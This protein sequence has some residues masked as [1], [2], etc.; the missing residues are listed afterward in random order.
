MSDQNRI[1]QD[2]GLRGELAY[3]YGFKRRAHLHHCPSYGTFHVD[4]APLAQFRKRYSRQ[5]TPIT[6]RTLYIKALALAIQRT[7][8]ANAILFKKWWGLLGQRRIVRFQNVD[9]NLPITREVDGKWV[10]FIGTI[11]QAATKSL[12]QIQAELTA[13]QRCPPEESFAL[14]RLKKF[15]QMPLWL[16]QL[17][18]W[19]L[20]LSPRFYVD[21]VGT[22]GITF[23][24]GDFY[25]TFFP[26][27]PTTLI[28]G[29][30]AAQKR[31]V[32]E[33]DQMVIKQQLNCTAM[34]DNYV[35]SGLAIARVVKDFKD[36][37]EGGAFVEEELSR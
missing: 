7:P 20:T 29:I 30:G 4:L 9:V 32:V 37:L 14:R 17:V 27:G 6:L 8:E 36:H 10:T 28:M 23:I 11:R 25:D 19:A 12:A 15:S 33:N 18:H 2:E 34:G 16:A 5:V 31:V 24:D 26:L 1:V 35:V 3:V 22:C 13:F 21:Q